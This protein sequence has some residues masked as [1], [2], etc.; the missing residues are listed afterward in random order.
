MKIGYILSSDNAYKQFQSCQIMAFDFNKISGKNI[1]IT[2]GCGFLG[3]NLAR[4]L[5]ELNTNVTIFSRVEKSR[6]NLKDIEHKLKF[7]E[8]N[9]TNDSDV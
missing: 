8:G 6:E 2:G 5:V 3:S 4:R 7:I 9:L 1:L